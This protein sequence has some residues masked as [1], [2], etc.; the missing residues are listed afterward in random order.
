MNAIVEKYEAPMVPQVQQ[1]PRT[2][3]DTIHEAVMK[4]TP[5]EVIRELMAM[6]NQF[7]AAAARR[8]FEAAMADAKSELPIIEKN[9]H[10][11]FASKSGGAKTDYDHEDLAAVVS[12][13]A[14]ILG[15]HGLSH[16]FRVE[17]V[18]SIKVVCIISHK[19]G[20]FEESE[21]KGAP[22]NTGNK[23]SIQ[24]VGS[25]IT[26]LQRYSLKAAL[27]LAAGKD[28]D[29]RATS[30]AEPEKISEAQLAE[31]LAL[32]DECGVDKVKYCRFREIDSFA[33]ILTT[34]FDRA[35]Q[36]L[37]AKRKAAA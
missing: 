29:G 16:R 28:D 21:L 2:M 5:I 35:K 19:D 36:D 24:A 26:Y 37:R 33:E 12:V 10:V 22:D 8:A 3:L 34:Q 27:G 7:E 13:V 20:Y 6:H 25:T 23:N 9:K 4:G 14:P 11:G 30:Q 17:Q 1:A 18:E 31:L 15:R 32:A